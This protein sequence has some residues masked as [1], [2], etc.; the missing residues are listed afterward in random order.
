MREVP[1][2][3][4]EEETR[5]FLAEMDENLAA[6]EDSL[7]NLEERG[8]TSE[9][10]EVFR[11]FHT[12]K[13]SAGALG[14]EGIARL[15]HAS[16]NL[17]EGLRKGAVGVSPDVVDA[18]LRSIDRLRSMRAEIAAGRDPAGDEELAGLITRLATLGHDASDSVSAR[19]FEAQGR[20]EPDGD[21]QDRPS[22]VVD[23]GR[24]Y[25]LC[26]TFDDGCPMPAVRAYQVLSGLAALG[27][28][29]SSSPTAEEIE[30]EQV[31]D[32]LRASVLS[33]S[34]PQEIQERISTVPDVAAVRIREVSGPE[35]ER[36]TENLEEARGKA[37]TI[38][39]DV[40]RLDNLMNLVGELV[41]D[42]TRLAE[43]TKTIR[44]ENPDSA[45]HQ[46]VELTLNRMDRVVS[47][48]Q[49]EVMKARMLPIARVFR[50]FPRMV[51][52]L[53]RKTGKEVKLVM[54]GEDTELDRAVIEE[55]TDPLI[56][57][58]RNAVDHGIEPP[59]ERERTG[60]PR[61][62]R[63]DLCA[64]YQEE[65]ILIEVSDDGR[66]IDVQKLKKRAVERGLLSE[67]GAR[68][69]GDLAAS[70]LV[71]LPGVS[72]AEDVSEVSG[73][74]VGMD[75]VR[76]R[77]QRIGGSVDVLSVAG[78]GVTFTIGLPLTLAIMRGLLVRADYGV[79]V[80]PLSSVLEIV[81]LSPEN[82]TTISGRAATVLRGQ[83]I[84]LLN[85]AGL[86][87]GDRG[88]K[89]RGG[90]GGWGGIAHGPSSQAGSE[91]SGSRPSVEGVSADL[92]ASQA[93]LTVILGS[94]GQRVGLV[95]DSLVG[96]QEVVVKSLSDIFGKV[97]YVSGVTILGDGGIAPILDGMEILKRTNRS[98]GTSGSLPA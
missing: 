10:N 39:I 70:E 73:R 86:L 23:D 65:R 91:A 42:R 84:P 3:R 49:Q 20:A 29:I 6:A 89:S 5:I 25:E 24:F 27:R 83:L 32:T 44:S 88:G 71:F 68:S 57:L 37:A 55:L 87:R 79:Y 58:L 63:I 90:A 2:E 78:R 81:R 82:V 1:F 85:L 8:S 61:Q 66:G 95:V 9:L 76:H 60:K 93:L 34:A 14:C 94:T 38:R 59:D 92:L 48:L 52:D 98:T 31:K 96:E 43:L 21:E 69:L 45:G 28:I 46:E 80:I 67:E 62:G 33:I 41:I 56:H 51:R 36:E 13:G 75:I 22:G 26:V 40:E 11:A 72:T 18:L 4:D 77:I 47:E 30:R 97:P 7:L 35:T 16:E 53:A 64:R 17:L 12:I 54:S 74:G 19:E 15:A 50:R